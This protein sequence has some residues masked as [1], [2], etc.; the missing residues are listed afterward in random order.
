MRSRDL[1]DIET[2]STGEIDLSR[3]GRVLMRKRWWVIGPTAVAMLGAAIFVNVV[4]PRYN[5]EVRLLLENQENFLTRAEKGEHSDALAP[6]PD[7]EAVQSQIQL[8][9]SRDLARRVIKTLELQG[10]D[11]FDPL[12]KGIGLTSRALTLFGLGRD[13]TRMTPEERILESFADKL[14]VLSPTKTRVLSIEFTSRDPDLTAR[15][16]NTVAGAYIEMQQEAKRD[17]ARGAAQSLGLLVDDLK[18]RVTDAEDRAEEFRVKQGLF[19][20]SNNNTI[21]A[22]HLSDLNNQ[23]SLSRTSHADAQ[24]KAKVLRDMLR[25]GR[26]GDIPDVAN[27][28]LIRNI[29]ERRVTLRAQLALELRTLMPGHPR[30]KELQAQ[31]A[32]LDHEWRAAAVSTAHTLENEARIAG[33]RVEN[34]TRALDAQKKVAGA[35]G[36]DEV[37]LRELERAGRLFKEQLEIATAKYQAALARENAKATPADARIIQRALAPQLPSFPKKVP[38]TVFATLAGLMLSAGAIISGELLSGRASPRARYAPTLAESAAPSDDAQVAPIA[39]PPAESPPAPIAA[40]TD[41]RQGAA[42]KAAPC[43]K[44]LV[45]NC[46]GPA[47]AFDAAVAVSRGLSRKGRAILVA[48]DAGDEAYDQ[49]LPPGAGRPKGLTDFIAGEAE[50]AQ[51]IHRDAES[52]LHV[53]PAGLVGGAPRGE[54]SPVVDAL[55]QTYDFVVFATSSR[56][57]VVALA[58][59]FDVALVAGADAA[60][61]ELHDELARAGADVHLLEAPDSASGLAAA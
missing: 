34:L 32:D 17:T 48:A 47:Q 36:A 15:A 33:S 8:L 28:A 16:A 31:L 57:N 23:L 58:P 20:G 19:V 5:A 4:K 53:I 11:E 43:V 54:M 27:N 21:S 42:R 25:Q 7:A 61:R 30:I 52:R 6:A 45:A 9:T 51:I 50:F 13:L 1:Q 3:I 40:T 29:S 39:A 35:A 60:A 41:E 12:A 37:H 46:D 56:D 55:A 49:L 18:T 22:Q 14:A 10:N 44:A 38:I 26:I 2:T 59:L 24:A